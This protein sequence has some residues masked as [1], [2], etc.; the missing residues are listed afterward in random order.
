[1]KNS[2]ATVRL[3][4]ISKKQKRLKENMENSMLMPTV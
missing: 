1:M 3:Q 2:Q 4:A